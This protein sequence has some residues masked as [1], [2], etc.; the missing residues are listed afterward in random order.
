MLSN[1]GG[2]DPPSEYSARSFEDLSDRVGDVAHSFEGLSGPMATERGEV[3]VAAASDQH[4][5]ATDINDGAG[6]MYSPDETQGNA[7]GSAQILSSKKNQEILSHAHSMDVAVNAQVF[8]AAH[9]SYSGSC[10]FDV[11]LCIN[12]NDPTPKQYSFIVLIP[13]GSVEKEVCSTSEACV[14]ASIV[15]DKVDGSSGSPVISQIQKPRQY[16]KKKSRKLCRKL[17][18]RQSC[19]RKRSSFDYQQYR[20]PTSNQDD[21]TPPVA[22]SLP[23]RGHS[24]T[25]EEVKKINQRLIDENHR[26]KKDFHKAE[27]R[28]KTLLADKK[29]LLRRLRLE[30]KATNKL[31]ESMQDKAQDTMERARNILSKANQSKKDAEM[32]K[33]EIES[34][35][36]SLLGVQME[37][38]KQS[39]RL[40]KKV[41]RMAQTHARRKTSLTQQQKLLDRDINAKTQQWNTSL[42][43]AQRKMQCSIKQLQ[44]ERVMW[45]VL[46]QEAELRCQDAQLEAHRQK[47]NGRTLVQMQVDK[48]IRKERELK[49]YMLELKEIHAVQLHKERKA[50]RVAI[51]SSKH[52]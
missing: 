41:A 40:K 46:S 18:R 43:L 5:F 24:P 13:L 21:T 30:S 32:L 17:D 49:L 4:S 20:H 37:I 27:H 34:S 38:R 26:L 12:V 7:G 28:L 3:A 35:K 25:K 31:I 22:R 42:L 23:N 9:T 39:A 45:Q 11:G 2:D 51:Q 44:K 1:I 50:K 10:L 15:T 52:W 14:G 48:A 19:D 6:V 29:D 33:D 36:N 8:G 16:F 47:S